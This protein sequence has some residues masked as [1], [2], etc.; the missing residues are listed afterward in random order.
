MHNSCKHTAESDK[1]GGLILLQEGL[2]SEQGAEPPGSL[3]LTTDW[4]S[5]GLHHGP[6]TYNTYNAQLVQA[7]HRIR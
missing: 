4:T 2:K 6:Q 3:T 1:P 7:Y 5:F